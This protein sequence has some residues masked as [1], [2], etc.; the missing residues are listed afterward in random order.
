VKQEAE[1]LPAVGELH[2]QVP[3]LL[4]DPVAIRV[5]DACDELDASALQR[6]E[7]ED[8]DAGQPDGLDGEEVAGQHRRRLL[9]QELPPAR[10]VA[11]G[12][13]RQFMTDQDRTHRAR[14]DRD[15][16]PAELADDAP[17]AP[18][19]VLPCEA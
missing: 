14:R 17:I 1:G 10:A 8:V 4:R 12:R 18:G 2:Q 5:A 15:S 11:F 13:R 16:E 7:E 19:R 3:G 6:D 9:A